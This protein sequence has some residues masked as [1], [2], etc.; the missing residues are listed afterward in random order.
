MNKTIAII[1]SKNRPLQLDGCLKSFYNLCS[2]YKNI[3]VNVLYK[4]DDERFHN[5]YQTCSLENPTVDFVNETDFRNNV[6]QLAEKYK[7]V[8]F[9]T[10]DN[11][12]THQFSIKEIE[13][14]LSENDRILGFSLRLG[15]NTTYCYPVGKEQKIPAHRVV[16][17]KILL[18]NWV[19]AELDFGYPIELSSSAYRVKNI[20]PILS[21]CNYHNPNELEYIADFCKKYLQ[22]SYPYMACYDQSVAFCNPVNKVN[23]DNK[24]RSGLKEQYSI[25]SLLTIYE[26]CGRININKFNG[27]ISKG[28]HQEVEIEIEYI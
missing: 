14:L 13:K 6:Q 24:N 11:L 10:D 12:F 25:D 8:L 17:T 19:N 27:F 4:V 7:Y 1:F 16:N 9:L 26:M 20:Q 15:L 18:W 2:D 3:D 28:A 5:V 23:P 22:I 21:N